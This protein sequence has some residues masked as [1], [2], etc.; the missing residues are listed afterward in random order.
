MVETQ[1][2]TETLSRLHSISKQL[3]NLIRSKKEEVTSELN[4]VKVGVKEFD[5]KSAYYCECIYCFVICKFCITK[6]NFCIHNYRTYGCISFCCS[7]FA[8]QTHSN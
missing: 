2:K 6:T 7:F 1:K 5:C 4:G 3:D 8:L